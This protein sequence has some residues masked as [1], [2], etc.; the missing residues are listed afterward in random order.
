METNRKNH[1]G[2]LEIQ[3]EEG[4]LKRIETNIKKHGVRHYT[5]SNDFK[6]SV[7]NAWSKKTDEEIQEIVKRRENTCEQKFGVKNPTKLHEIQLKIL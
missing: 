7:K 6:S 3:T 2:V 5:Q 1:G 4:K